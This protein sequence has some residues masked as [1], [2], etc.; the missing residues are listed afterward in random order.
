MI[1][2]VCTCMQMP[3]KDVGCLL[4]KDADLAMARQIKV[5]QA[6]NRSLNDAVRSLTEEKEKMAVEIVVLTTQQ[7]KEVV[8]GSA[9]EGPALG[10]EN[11]LMIVDQEP[12]EEA[13]A[14][15]GMLL[16]ADSAEAD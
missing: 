13:D 14:G 15:S 6:E 5:L 2:S 9:D 11:A 1:A 7:M 12:K 10:G 4:A 16:L 3:V 8:D